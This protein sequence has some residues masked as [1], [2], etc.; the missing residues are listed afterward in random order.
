M[1]MV[2]I[3][4]G[5]FLMGSPD[6][7]VDDTTA[8]TPK[9]N[10][11][12]G[13]Q[14]WVAIRKPLYVSAC[15]VT[16]GQFKKFV[17]KT[18][19]RTDAESNPKLVWRWAE[20]DDMGNFFGNFKR[21]ELCNW[22]NPRFDKIEQT[23]EHPV[24]CISW[25]DAIEFC[26]WLTH[27]EGKVYRLP[28]EAEWEYACRA[29]TTTPFA[30]GK[31]LSSWQA[32][33]DGAYPYGETTKRPYLMATKQV[34][35]FKANDF[36]LY[37][38]HGNVAEWCHDWYQADYYSF[39]PEKDPQGPGMGMMRVVRGG[40]WPHVGGRCRSA[41]RWPYPPEESNNTIGFRVVCVAET[42]NAP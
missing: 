1:K 11:N 30:Y 22:L 31:S 25:N 5:K 35:S 29:G 42:K 23:D 6:E 28:T 19:Y 10:L 40:F 9:H 26:R 36:G 18:R 39:S 20:F 7:E 21:D 41:W 4:A 2:L 24:T 16:V 15:E 8:K 14:H 17:Q 33:F 38:M 32:N 3:P 13:P 34:A 37:D 27:K 12:E